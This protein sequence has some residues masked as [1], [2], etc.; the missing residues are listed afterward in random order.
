MERG[1]EVP[2]NYAPDKSLQDS[3][4]EAFAAL[5]ANGT[6]P[7]RR[8][9]FFSTLSR[10]MVR[11]RCSASSR[12]PA[13]ASEVRRF[14]RHSCPRSRVMKTMRKASGSSS[15]AARRHAGFH[16]CHGLS[17]SRMRLKAELN[18]LGFQGAR[19]QRAELHA[20]TLPSQPPNA[21]F[22]AIRASHVARLESLRKTLQMGECAT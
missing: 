17:G 14:P 3:V 16:V 8:A 18:D 22:M 21:S 19:R 10:N 7:S 15:M 5:A 2:E 20:R 12:F 11:A 4:G 9:I 6:L 13:S 1:D